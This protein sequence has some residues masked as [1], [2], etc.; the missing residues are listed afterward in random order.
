MLEFKANVEDKQKDDLISSFYML[1][2]T[3]KAD[4]IANKR[5]YSLDEIE[6]KLSVIC[7][8]KKVDFGDSTKE[9]T[10]TVTFN[11]T[12]D[13]NEIPAYISALRNTQKERQ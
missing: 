9:T 3:D 7:F 10:P 5:K 2:D 1:S 8:R 4:V 12:E 13:D 11:L 6:A